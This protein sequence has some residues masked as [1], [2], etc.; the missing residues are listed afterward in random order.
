M[1][2]K[3]LPS[4]NKLPSDTDW[5]MVTIILVR[6]KSK[7]LLREEIYDDFEKSLKPLE[8][9]VRSKWKVYHWNHHGRNPCTE[10]LQSPSLNNKENDFFLVVALMRLPFFFFSRARGWPEHH[11][12]M[13]NSSF[14]RKLNLWVSFWSDQKYW[15]ATSPLPSLKVP[16]PQSHPITILR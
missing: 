4:G 15:R 12:E 10:K 6:L 9:G 1:F 14:E 5:G 8:N 16:S 11:R 2:R 13:Y 7:S 3:K